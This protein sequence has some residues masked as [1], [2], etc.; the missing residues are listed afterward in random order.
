MT[1]NIEESKPNNKKLW[2]ILASVSLTIIGCTALAVGLSSS[3]LDDKSDQANASQSEKQENTTS[4]ELSVTSVEV[5]PT[6]KELMF[7]VTVKN[8]NESDN[9]LEYEIADQDRVV[10]GEGTAKTSEFKAPVK[11]SGSAYYRVKVRM[12]KSDGQKSEWSDSKTV[13][14]ADLKGFKTLEPKPEYYDTG[15][16]KGTDNSL[17]GAK[18]AIQTAWGIEEVT[19]QLALSSCLPLNSGEM[20]PKLLLPPIPSVLPNEVALK[21]IT[22]QWDGSAISIIYIWCQ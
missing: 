22:T 20:T 21:Y 7:S 10:K 3:S 8:F 2:L 13:K 11:V 1:N 15:W 6:E 12:V 9:S 17:D 19:D 14:L 4:S 18:T 16:A 5:T